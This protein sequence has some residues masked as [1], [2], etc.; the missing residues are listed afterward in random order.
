MEGVP[1][2]E[3]GQIFLYTESRFR[4]PWPRPDRPADFTFTVTLSVARLFRMSKTLAT[5][6]LL[7]A[8][9][10]PAAGVVVPPPSNPPPSVRP[11][12]R[13]NEKERD[14]RERD[15]RDNEEREREVERR[16]RS[17]GRR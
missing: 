12:C 10:L 1:G 6:L 4:N 14:A 15:E 9:W 11:P 5:L 2:R 13:K 3:Q 8:S 17:K 16:S 7:A